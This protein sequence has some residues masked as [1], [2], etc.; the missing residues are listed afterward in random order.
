MR[1]SRH[2][3]ERNIE[4]LPLVRRRMGTAAALLHKKTV[5][6]FTK[7]IEGKLGVGPYMSLPNGQCGQPKMYMCS[8]G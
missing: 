8:G 7:Q 6:C 1:F 5:V 3:V 2:G 4:F